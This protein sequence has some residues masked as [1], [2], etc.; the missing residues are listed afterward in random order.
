MISKISRGKGFRGVFDYLLSKQGATI[1][2][3]FE[4]ATA[5]DL[6]AEFRAARS[7]RPDIEKPVWH[8][9]LSLSPD[10]YLDDDTWQR[11]VESY[12]AKMGVDTSEHQHVII[13]H[14][15]TGHDH[16]HVVVN[17]IA[18]SGATW[19]P[20]FDIRKS[21]E[22]MRELERE[23]G[24][25]SGERK[26]D[27]F[28]E[29]K[30]KRGEVEKALREQEPPVKLIV[31]EAIKE[32]V[33]DKP[34][35]ATFIGRLNEQG[36]IAIPNVASTGRMNGFSF[37]LDGRVDKDGVPVVVKGSD[38]GAKWSK[39]K[40]LVDYEVDRDGELLKRIK[41]EATERL[42]RTGGEKA[43]SQG[44]HDE[45][46]GD[47]AIDERLGGRDQEADGTMRRTG[48]ISQGYVSS[49]VDTTPEGYSGSDT[50]DEGLAGSD[51]DMEIQAVLDSA[52]DDNGVSEW[53]NTALG[54]ATDAVDT[55][56]GDE[57][58]RAND[59]VRVKAHIYA[60]QKR[61]EE[62]SQAMGSQRYRITCVS[63]VEGK[64]TW[65]I[66]K[67]GDTEE[68]YS[69]EQVR[70]MIEMLSA[71]NAQGY[72]IYVTPVD[73]TKHY[74]LLDDLKKKQ[75]DEILSSDLKPALV[76]ESSKDNYQVLFVCEKNAKDVE[77]SDREKAAA[78]V[79]LRA[80]QKRF[81]ADQGVGGTEWPFRVAGFVNKKQGRDNFMVKLHYA[82]AQ[83]CPKIREAIDK[84]KEN[85][86]VKQT[87]RPISHTKAFEKREPSKDAWDTFKKLWRKQRDL[88]Y[89]MVKNGNWQEIDRSAIDFRVACDMLKLGFD[90]EDVAA[91][92][93]GSPKLNERHNDP[94]DYVSRTVAKAEL[95]I[96]RD[97][98][99]R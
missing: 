97:D 68:F 18:M 40:E 47:I 86:D 87:K 5:R 12:L 13:R 70:D 15:D 89:H 26:N 21:H 4:G 14:S 41:S 38:V 20:V 33:A 29:P 34:D 35:I 69:A 49:V 24:L 59:Q 76:I 8:V 45:H 7:L 93:F 6:S 64:A 92:L 84:A 1:L 82:S 55:T 42:N 31:S 71:K 65:V 53:V 73:P 85:V 94:E 39:L 63:R 66:G 74:F 16:V 19:R 3:G 48:E 44:L 37:A 23:F 51:E 80:L 50:G 91:C 2:N 17:R 81:G 83:T 11:V 99:K 79:V 46:S 22:V 72:D 77:D 54:V 62:Q 28:G 36:I 78:Q 56:A 25:K 96:S 10:E 58:L 88:A 32:V 30:L 43:G 75:V 57:G 60:K 95:E 67:K 98:I 9:S 61:W 27:G 90:R 52:D